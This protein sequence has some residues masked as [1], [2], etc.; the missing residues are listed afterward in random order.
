MEHSSQKNLSK[1]LRGLERYMRRTNGEP[2]RQTQAAATKFKRPQS[3]STMR[4]L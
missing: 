4:G 3:G 1:C 2:E